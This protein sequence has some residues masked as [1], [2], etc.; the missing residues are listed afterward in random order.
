[1]DAGLAVISSVTPGNSEAVGDAGVLVATD[2][3]RAL[4]RA[5]E[6]V[7]GDAQRRERLGAAARERA[8]SAFSEDRFA[9]AVRDAYA[10]AQPSP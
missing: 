6:D 2:D 4:T 1:M 9:A 3:E 10:A 8:R 7:A 5:L